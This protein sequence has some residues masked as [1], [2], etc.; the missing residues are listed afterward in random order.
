MESFESRG[1][2]SPSPEGGALS[3][4]LLSITLS[5]V[6]TSLIRR[7]LGPMW[8]QGWANVADVG[9]TLILHWAGVSH[10]NTLLYFQLTQYKFT[11]YTESYRRPG[12]LPWPSLAYKHTSPRQAPYKWPHYCPMPARTR[13]KLIF[14]FCLIA[15]RSLSI[16]PANLHVW[17][18]FWR[19]CWM[20]CLQKQGTLNGCDE[21]IL[22]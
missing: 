13:G 4:V 5:A 10:V 20:F 18:L 3:T 12:R 16:S 19:S 15:T 17:K 14:I 6:I 2:G 7:E 1:V 11:L 21:V 9:S 22:Y 8:N